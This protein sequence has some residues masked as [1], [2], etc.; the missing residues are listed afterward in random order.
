MKYEFIFLCFIIHGPNHPRKKLNVMLKPFI[1]E[2]K[3]LL[4]GFEA[5]NVF[6]NKIFKLQVVYLWSVHDFLAYAI[7]VSLSTHGRLTCLYYG[8]DMDCFC[9]A[10]GGKKHLLRLSSTLV[11]Q[12]TPL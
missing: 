1:E 3:E 6:K 5:Y 4:K 9:L 7:F 2:L 8:S 11:A 10:H 12:E